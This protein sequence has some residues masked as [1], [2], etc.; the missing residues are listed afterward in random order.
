MGV[1][2]KFVEPAI[3]VGKH[4]GLAGIF[5]SAISASFLEIVLSRFATQMRKLFPPVVRGCVIM[6]IGLTFMPVGIEWMGGSNK[7]LLLALTVMILVIVFNRFGKGLISTS[8]ILISMMVGYALAFPL[9]M[10]EPINIF[11]GGLV[12]FPRPLEYGL[13]FNI[14]AILP[15]LVVYV[16]SMIETI[17]DLLAIEETC[18]E[19]IGFKR[20]GDGILAD[21]AASTLAGIF[22]SMPLTSFSQNIGIISLTGVASKWVVTLSGVFFIIVG[23]FP[24]VGS[25][26]GAMPQPVIGGAA[27]LMFGMVAVTGIRL[28]RG[29]E[30]SNKNMLIM[31]VSLG[32]GV[33]VAAAPQAL[34]TLPL[35]LK[36]LLSSGITIGSLAAIILNLAIPDKS[37]NGDELGAA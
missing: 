12:A 25:I 32:L 31:A 27:V 16:I 2:I 30:M 24:P 9:G 34:E 15:F 19:K 10:V 14:S 22:N 1:S 29:A 11:G 28:L 7:N 18:N 35:T 5:G 20:L 36:M 3:L 37:E 8:S 21:G 26:L 33:G 6:L 17:G 4:F 23:L 13:T